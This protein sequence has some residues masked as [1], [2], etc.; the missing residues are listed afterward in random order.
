MIVVAGQCVEIHQHIL[1]HSNVIH[2]MDKIQEGLRERTKNL[3]TGVHATEVKTGSPSPKI[4]LQLP[5]VVSERAG[6]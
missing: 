6:Q 1:L 4:N 2:Y 3:F 5:G